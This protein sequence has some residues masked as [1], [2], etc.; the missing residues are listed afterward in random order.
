VRSSWLSQRP[1]SACDAVRATA[2]WATSDRGR[3]RPTTRP[4]PQRRLRGGA[5]PEAV[6]AADCDRG[7]KTRSLRPTLALLVPRETVSG[8]GGGRRL[9]PSRRGVVSAVAALATAADDDQSSAA[10]DPLPP[11]SCICGKRQQRADYPY[12]CCWALPAS[13]AT[14]DN[15]LLLSSGDLNRGRAGRRH[16]RVRAPRWQWTART[17]RRRSSLGGCPTPERGHVQAVGRCRRPPSLTG[18]DAGV[19]CRPAAAQQGDALPGRPAADRGDRRGHAPR[20]RQSSTTCARHHATSSSRH[21]P[22]SANG[23]AKAAL[24]T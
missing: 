21:S 20:R 5:A 17:V 23:A 13:A 18:H 14:R 7:R 12:P 6:I 1:S 10:R 19:P 3:A 9:L 15:A 2:P 11:R 8:H 24:A 16:G 4:Q 22:A